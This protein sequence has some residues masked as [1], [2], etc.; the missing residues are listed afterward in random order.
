MKRP[1]DR[2]PM[3][4]SSI[5]TC[6]AKI[7]ELIK[8]VKDSDIDRGQIDGILEMH[9]RKFIAKFG[10]TFFSFGR[11]IHFY[12]WTYDDDN[13]VTSCECLGVFKAN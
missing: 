7:C 1:N 9:N 2:S 10:S 4:F 12:E 6:N 13:K 11:S 3:S 8:A 5:P